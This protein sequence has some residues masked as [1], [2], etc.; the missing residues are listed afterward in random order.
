MKYL[1]PS[2]IFKFSI[3][4]TIIFVVA[5]A[6]PSILCELIRA[7]TT[8]DVHVP[9]IFVL[10]VFVISFATD[11]YF[12]GLLASIA[13]VFAVNWAFTYPYGKL[14]FTIYGYPLTFFTMF[15]V[16]VATST[17]A[18]TLREH[19]K[20]KLESERERMKANLLRSVSHDLRTPLTSIGGNLTAV[21]ES[22]EILDDK[23]KIELLKNA[24]N[25]VEWLYQMVEN[26]LSV[27]RINADEAK[28]ITKSGELLE[29]VISEA[30]GKFK[31]N[32]KN[33]E[34]SISCPEEILFVPMDPMLIEQVLLNLMDNSIIHG[35]TT[36]K[37]T[38]S[39][40]NIEKNIWVSV[41]DNGEGIDKKI[42]PHLFEIGEKGVL[43]SSDKNRFMG[44]GLMT[45]KTIINA[46]GGEIKAYNES[47]GGAKFV[48]TLPRG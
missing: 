40:K 15:V 23:E 33:I 45:C 32:N 39:A 26:L 18:S 3:K 20:I 38:I 21:L 46:H 17:L 47:Q 31:R 6:I 36:T 41:I 11:G 27:T 10:S 4:D 7:T 22:G 43:F 9:L 35:K 8:S 30:V 13:S 1:K 44:L 28:L 19:E 37:I 29:E 34:V 48:F 16:G 42:L 2:Y 24:K 25:D 14:D 12:Y 5:M